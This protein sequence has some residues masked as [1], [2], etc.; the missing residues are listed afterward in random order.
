MNSEFNSGAKDPGAGYHNVTFVPL[1]PGETG[2]AGQPER[3][4][5]TL[6][7]QGVGLENGVCHLSAALWGPILTAGCVSP[8][9]APP[10]TP[11]VVQCTAC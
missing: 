11:A 9:P 8:P 3:G 1:G 7:L 5:V 4:W 6:C 10:P 2:A